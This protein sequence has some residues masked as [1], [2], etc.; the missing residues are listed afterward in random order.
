MKAIDLGPLED[1]REGEGRRVPAGDEEVLV[2]RVG[3]RLL[4]VGAFCSHEELPLEG[5]RLAGEDLWECPHHGGR[6]CLSTGAPAGMPVS[7]PVATFPIRE[8]DGRF[9][10]ETE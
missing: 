4:A 7:A 1:W 2:V 8:A 6:I 9:M 10:L 5:G 3:D